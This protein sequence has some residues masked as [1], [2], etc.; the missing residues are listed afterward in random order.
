M[1]F[2]LI[3]RFKINFLNSRLEFNLEFTGNDI[4]EL[5]KEIQRLYYVDYSSMEFDNFIKRDDEGILGYILNREQLK[6]R[7]AF[8]ITIQHIIDIINKGE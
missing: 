7:K 3:F 4:Y 5:L 6:I 2:R 1:K 8:P